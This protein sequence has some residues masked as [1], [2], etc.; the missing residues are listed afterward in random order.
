MRTNKFMQA[1]L[2]ENKENIKGSFIEVDT[3]YE[4][5]KKRSVVARVG[6]SLNNSIKLASIEL[7]KT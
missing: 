4:G 6:I 7:L 2:Q 1:Y 3:L 5:Y